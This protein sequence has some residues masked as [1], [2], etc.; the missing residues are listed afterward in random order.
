MEHF[1]TPVL[2]VWETKGKSWNMETVEC[3]WW[4][5][6]KVKCG[7]CWKVGGFGEKGEWFW[8]WGKRWVAYWFREKGTTELKKE[9]SAGWIDMRSDWKSFQISYI[10]GSG[11]VRQVHPFSTRYPTQYVRVTLF[12]TRLNS[13]VG[14]NPIYHGRIGSGW[15]GWS[16]QPNPWSPLPTIELHKVVS[17]KHYK[18]WTNYE[19]T[20]LLKFY[21]KNVVNPLSTKIQWKWHKLCSQQNHLSGT[22]NYKKNN[23]SLK[24]SYNTKS[25]GLKREQK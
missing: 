17:A 1:G 20:Q 16:G 19:L 14:L 4:F 12:S 25:H 24:K 3:W 15:P 13:R 9:K 2:K 23:T 7:F 22:K 18:R 8:F 5:F 6:G 10:H 11:Q 21:W